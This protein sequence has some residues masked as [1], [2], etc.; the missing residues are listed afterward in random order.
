MIPQTPAISDMTYIELK[1]RRNFLNEKRKNNEATEEENKEY[2]RIGEKIIKIKAEIESE[3]I[4][5]EGAERL[6]SL[7]EFLEDRRIEREN[8]FKN[9]KEKHE[10]ELNPSFSINYH[11]FQIL[12]GHIADALTRARVQLVAV[13]FFCISMPKMITQYA[14]DSID[15]SNI[16]QVAATCTFVAVAVLGTGVVIV[17]AVM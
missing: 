8:I 1:E 5:K 17:A 13:A 3:Q 12:L 15:E 10:R 11:D 9:I 4:D 2:W 7:K 16:W 6:Q 14:K